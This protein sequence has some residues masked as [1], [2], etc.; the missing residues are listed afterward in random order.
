VR[1]TDGRAAAGRA[2]TDTEAGGRRA[3][4]DRGV[5]EW[6]VGNRAGDSQANGNPVDSSRG[7]GVEP[8]WGRGGVRLQFVEP[9]I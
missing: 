3:D 4:A 1:A 9:R 5:D 8:G 6:V 2:A 7:G